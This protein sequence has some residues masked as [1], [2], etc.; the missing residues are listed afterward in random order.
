MKEAGDLYGLASLLLFA[1]V[2]AKFDFSSALMTLGVLSLVAAF[3][4]F[5]GADS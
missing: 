2:W 1:S 4:H 3:F 5:L